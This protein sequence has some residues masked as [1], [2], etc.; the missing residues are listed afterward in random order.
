[1]IFTDILK[2]CSLNRNTTVHI[3]IWMNERKW[4]IIF[5]YVYVVGRENL[6]CHSFGFFKLYVLVVREFVL[7]LCFS[8]VFP[9]LFIFVSFFYTIVPL[10]CGTVPK[11]WYYLFL[12]FYLIENICK[13]VYLSLVIMFTTFISVSLPI[14]LKLFVFPIC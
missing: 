7:L 11:V 6:M 8:F 4:N 3:Y 1:M 12:S 9:L 13:P 5:A 2:L 14:T 10:D